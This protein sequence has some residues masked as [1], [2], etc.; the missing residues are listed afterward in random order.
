[1]F[2]G[3]SGFSYDEWVGTFFPE[4]T[5]RREMLAYYAARFDTVEI[6]YSFRK[7]PAE[8]TFRSWFEGT[9]DGFVF[10]LKAPQRITHLLRLRNAEGAVTEFVASA[11]VLGEKLGPILFQCPPNLVRDDDILQAL[12]QGLP[13]DL[14]YVFEFRHPSWDEAREGLVARGFGWCVAETD[15]RPRADEAIDD[16][17]FAY[18]RLRRSDYGEEDLT[19]WAGKIEA[20]IGS[21]RDVYCY[22]K[23]EERGLGPAYASRLGSILGRG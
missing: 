19:R 4:N 8:S 6:N 7:P 3:T 12:L 21:G 17:P 14:R 2:L 15:E 20:V 10:A 16:G 5:K 9:P 23:H 22:L 18:L 13:R 11:R 1:M